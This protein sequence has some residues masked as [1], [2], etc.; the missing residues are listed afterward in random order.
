MESSRCKDSGDI[1]DHH[2]EEIQFYQNMGVPPPSRSPIERQRRRISFRNFRNL[3]KRNCDATGKPLISMYRKNVPFPVYD[4]NYWWSDNWSPFDFGKDINFNKPFFE[5][6]K[7]LSDKVPRYHI[8]NIQSENCLY[9]N[10]AMQSKNC[11][12]VFGCVRNEDCQIGHI[13]WECKDCIDCT[14]AYQSTHCTNS[15]DIVECYDVHY[16]HEATGCTNSYFLY[17]CIGCKNCFGGVGLRFAEY[18]FFNEQ[19][20]KEEYERRINSI[21]PLSRDAVTNMMQWV[22]ATKES[23]NSHQLFGKHIEN[24]SGNHIYEG[25]NLYKAY[26]AKRCEDSRYIFTGMDITNS[27]DISFTG[28]PARFCY[29]CLTLINCERVM[30]SQVVSNLYN[31]QYCEFCSTGGELFGCNGI[32]NA[33]H[34]ILNKA[35][36]KHEYES[37]KVKLILHMKE[38]GEWGEFFPMSISPFYY[39][40]TAAGDNMPISHEEVLM[41]DGL[42]NSRTNTH[43]A[44]NAPIPPEQ[45]TLDLVGK[46]F[47]CKLTSKEFKFEHHEVSVLINSKLP[48]PEISPE[49]RYLH[50]QGVKFPRDSGLL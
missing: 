39:E 12:L 8:I 5:Q 45:P 49:A 29:E 16:S 48:L 21:L 32:R 36:S 6:Y 7:D 33:N 42:T 44:S 30:F 46:V 41:R 2:P 27:Q 35:Y 40:E 23:I 11:Y 4:K 26:D 13:V 19:C 18:C 20:S 50:R 31:S 25:K 14:Y 1:F 10:A 34:V 43:K 38:T 37:L 24:C 9:A 17:D 3:Y 22:S 28:G 47:R 15:I